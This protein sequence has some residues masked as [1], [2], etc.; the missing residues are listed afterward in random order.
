MP[1]LLFLSYFDDLSV[2]FLFLVLVCVCVCVCANHQFLLFFS[3]FF[4]LLFFYYAQIYHIHWYISVQSSSKHFC[5]FRL[6]KKN[7]KKH[8]QPRNPAPGGMEHTATIDIPVLTLEHFS[9]YKDLQ[10]DVQVP[11]TLDKTESVGSV[12][13]KVLPWEDI[14]LATL[15]R[16]QFQ[17]IESIQGIPSPSIMALSKRHADVLCSVFNERR[18][19]Y[20]NG[21]VGDVTIKSITRKY[22]EFTKCSKEQ[23]MGVSFVEKKEDKECFPAHEKHAIIYD[24]AMALQND[25]TSLSSSSSQVF[26]SNKSNV[27]YTSSGSADSLPASTTT[28]VPST[29]LLSS[30]PSSLTSADLISLQVGALRASTKDDSAHWHKIPE[31]CAG[32]LFSVYLGSRDTKNFQLWLTQDKSS[33]SE[34]RNVREW[35]NELCAMLREFMK[36]EFG[37]DARDS[38]IRAW[39]RNHWDILRMHESNKMLRDHFMGRYD[40]WNQSF[41]EWS[42][43]VTAK[44]EHSMLDS[45][46]VLLKYMLHQWGLSETLMGPESH[47]DIAHNVLTAY[48]T[49]CKCSCPAAVTYINRYTEFPFQ[50]FTFN[51]IEIRS[52]LREALHNRCAK[53]KTCK[54]KQTLCKL[55]LLQSIVYISRAG[56]DIY[57]HGSKLGWILLGLYIHRRCLRW[58][59][60]QEKIICG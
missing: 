34:F 50:G 57:T 32:F 22:D 39:Y 4:F 10:K 56:Q 6:K 42:T 26:A 52:L 46:I 44:P 5:K 40:L 38:V 8:L 49:K 51:T 33:K 54:M 19:Q 12:V 28:T 7:I 13:E 37:V 48:K 2:L 35:V 18:R 58:H 31:Q 1:L 14:I 47:K 25:R 43:F 41:K 23:V 36:L 20:T 30:S 27:S 55:L 53:G 15:Y 60:K 3:Y 17:Y 21:S 45:D 11:I 59:T 29:P 9:F 16:A 24:I